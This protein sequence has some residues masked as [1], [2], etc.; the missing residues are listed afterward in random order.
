MAKNSGVRK[1]AAAV[2]VAAGVVV[3]FLILRPSPLP[4]ESAKATIGPMRVTVDEDGETRAHDRFVVAAP[5][6]GRLLRVELEEGDAVNEN[7]EV[8]RI[9][10][11]PLN[12]QQRE[13]V[14]ARIA[15]ADA[16]KRLADARLAHAREDYE[17]AKRDLARVEGLAREGI[18]SNQVLEQASTAKTTSGEEFEAAKF[19]A[20]AAASEIKVARSGLVGMDASNATHKVILLRSPVAGHVLRVVEK[21]ERVVLAGAPVL[22]IGD[23]NRIEVVTDVLTTDA[24]NVKPGAPVYLEG[25]GG[26]YPIRAKVRLIEPAGFTKISALGVEEKRVNVISDFADPP[27]GL[28][29]GYRVEARIVTWEGQNVLKIHGSAAFRTGETWSVFVIEGGRA[30]RK[31]VQIGHRNQTEV[32]ILQGLTAGQE[33]ILHPSNELKDGIRVRAQ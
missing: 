4:V 29:D 19:N 25:W 2:G 20:L 22:I 10:P 16:L 32:E 26:D 24:V 15:A 23:P 7:A 14:L 1:S 12:Q 6:P 13:E 3:L 28:S 11:V 17:Q 21:S 9:E 33:V 8:A 30:R 27:D 18:V 5:I 31:A